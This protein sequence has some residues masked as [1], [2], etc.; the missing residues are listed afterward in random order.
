M[1]TFVYASRRKPDTYVW[2]R[3]RDHPHALPAPLRE[4]L[5]ELRFVLEF[6]LDGERQLPH[7]NARDILAHLD[8]R[9]WHL[10]M[11]PAASRAL[12]KPAIVHRHVSRPP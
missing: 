10:Q 9:G 11:P 2:L 12:G 1:R 7:E 5:G 3:E 8:S 6:D 4:A